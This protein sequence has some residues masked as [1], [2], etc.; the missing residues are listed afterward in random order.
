MKKAPII[1]LVLLV[2]V[3]IVA[4]TLVDIPSL[5]TTTIPQGCT[6]I[7][8]ASNPGSQYTKILNDRSSFV[9]DADYCK[10]SGSMT[11]SD[12]RYDSKV[13]FRYG[14]TKVDGIT[15]DIA[16]DTNNDGVLEPFRYSR[17]GDIVAC[18]VTDEKTRIKPSLLTNVRTPEGFVISFDSM[19][20]YIWPYCSIGQTSNSGGVYRL[21]TRNP[22]ADV[23]LSTEPTEGCSS[24]KITCD[25]IPMIRAHFNFC[26]WPD[27]PYCTG[28]AD[29]YVTTTKQGDKKYTAEAVLGKSNTLTFTP[30]YD[31]GAPVTETTLYVQEYDCTCLTM[32]QQG[33]A[34]EYG[35]LQCT[36]GY[37]STMTEEMPL[38]SYSSILPETQRDGN[39]VNDY[40]WSNLP[41]CADGSTPQKTNQCNLWSSTRVGHIPMCPSLVQNIKQ[42]CDKPINFGL[43]QCYTWG[44]KIPCPT[45]QMCYSNSLVGAQCACSANGCADGS[46]KAVPLD[47]TKYYK[48]VTV[49]GCTSWGTTI[50]DCPSGLVF[51]EAEQQCVCDPARLCDP[52]TE[53]SVC[54][55]DTSYTE[56]VEQNIGGKMCFYMSD[57]I[58][59]LGETRCTD[60]AC[61]CE[62]VDS[63][64]LDE[65]NCITEQSYTQ[66]RQNGQDTCLSF[67][68]TT[69]IPDIT[70]I[71]DMSTDTLV[72]NTRI[73]CKYNTPG[74]QCPAGAICKD[75]LCAC[76]PA[77]YDTSLTSKDYDAE[78]VCGNNS[79]LKVLRSP[80]SNIGGYGQTG[81][82]YYTEESEKCGYDMICD[83]RE[84]TAQ[85]VNNWDEIG[86]S[87]KE[88]YGVNEN[89]VVTIVVTSNFKEDNKDIDVRAEL[90]EDGN[91]VV[92]SLGNAVLVD[93]ATGPDGEAK[94]DFAYGHPRSGI[95]EVLASATADG[96]TGTVKKNITIKKSL[97]IRLNC[98]LQAY[99]GRDTQCSFSPIDAE[100]LQAVSLVGAGSSKSVAIKQGQKTLSYTWGGTSDT[101]YF[102]APSMGNVNVTVTGTKDGFLTSRDSVIIPVQGVTTTHELRLEGKSIN[103]DN[104]VKAGQV[105]RLEIDVEEAG[106]KAGD[107]KQVKA[108]IRT[109]SG[110]D[111]P[112][113][114]KQDGDGTWYATYTFEQSGQT[115]HLKGDIIFNDPAKASLSL[116]GYQIVTE[117]DLGESK[118]LTSYGIIG[119]SIGIGVAVVFG[120]IM[121]ARKGGKTR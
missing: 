75:N 93:T 47:D 78:L 100:T 44:T 16:I 48:C 110:E 3:V 22:S 27:F 57:E 112:L 14:D 114:F 51:N 59:C 18:Y 28:M 10:V 92:D 61:S 79:V 89:L 87:T 56:C 66:C 60:G 91:P 76:D 86:I 34:C 64:V 85:C 49:N 2:V 65:I 68:G 55:T 94:I 33:Q 69:E 116:D 15:R 109:P 17:E 104:T 119:T 43:A 24:G 35:D 50:Y 21:Y 4:V 32:I 84:G 9:C 62:D 1:A 58:D 12:E 103:T 82:C 39:C 67:R 71:C 115:Y 98:D 54:T 36:S 88:A 102:K 101:F 90:Y 29:D 72:E 23:S 37:S 97:D 30:K 42:V 83:D 13:I 95:L 52:V 8:D 99:V 26:P 19:Y 25:Q 117:S 111:V 45:N 77:K 31:G 113:S 46:M 53:S 5:T 70:Q 105:A 80:V 74:Y 107:V 20:L 11:L 120:I 118:D 63:C 106:V 40:Y 6:F 73:G 108:S 96:I 41:K 7:Q 81:Y 121:L 38:S